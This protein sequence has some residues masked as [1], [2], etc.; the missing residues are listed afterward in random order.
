VDWGEIVSID[1]RTYELQPAR[2]RDFLAL[3][4]KAGLTMQMEPLGR[5][6]DYFTTELGNVNEIAH[7]LACDGLAGRTRRRAASSRKTM[8]NK[9]LVPTPFS[10]TK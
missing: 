5:L 8:N 6:V 2:V 3:S 9:I 4:E 10:P 7:I 1:H